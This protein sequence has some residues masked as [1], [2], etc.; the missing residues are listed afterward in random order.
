VGAVLK[1]EIL[2]M[3]GIANGANVFDVAVTVED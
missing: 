2:D 1:A 3:Q